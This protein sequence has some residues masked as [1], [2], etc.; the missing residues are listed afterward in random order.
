VAFFKR[1]LLA[2]LCLHLGASAYAASNPP[3]AQPGP[4]PVSTKAG[5][6]AAPLS[7]ADRYARR[8]QPHAPNRERGPNGTMLWGS[9]RSWDTEKVTPETSNVLVSVALSPV[10]PVGTDVKALQLKG[11][12]LEAAPAGTKV[13]GLVLQGSAS[14]G[15]PVEVAICGAESSPQFPEMVWYRIEA[16]NPMALEWENPCVAVDRAPSPRALAVSGVWD[17]TG[18]RKDSADRF[19][20]A[21]ENGAIAKCIGFGYKP[22]ASRNGKPLTDAHQACT[23]MARADYCGDGRSHTFRDNPMDMY[24]QLGVLKPTPESAPDWDPALSFEAAWGTDGALCIEHARDGRALETILAECP[25]RFRKGTA[26]ELGDGDHCS[27]QRVDGNPKA[28][29]LRNKSY[30]L[31]QGVAPPAPSFKR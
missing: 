5:S 3:S 22:W 29:L 7:E 15:E 14:D 20:F 18:A 19:T 23:R 13:D 27:I 10:K 8:C 12:S 21:C 2:G 17:A 25:N 11:G 1:F 6:S 28:A 31:P 26:V 4:K 30:G 9:R 16:W 24:D